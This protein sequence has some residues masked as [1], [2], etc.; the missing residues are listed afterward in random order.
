MKK[1]IILFA[2]ASTA[3]MLYVCCPHATKAQRFSLGLPERVYPYSVAM[4]NYFSIPFEN[5]KNTLMKLDEENKATYLAPL[6]D[7]KGSVHH[8]L[9]QMD[10]EGHLSFVGLTRALKGVFDCGKPFAF[11]Q[12]CI[13]ETANQLY[14]MDSN[15]DKI[16][17]LVKWLNYCAR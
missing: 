12:R 14:T 5:R 11:Y 17:C 15:S 4:E 9:W 1:K 8:I 13:Q 7:E 6:F 2:K 10:T 16:A 3:L